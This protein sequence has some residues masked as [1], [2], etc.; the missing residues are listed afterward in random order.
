M[1]FIC[2]YFK[3]LYFLSFTLNFSITLNY[4]FFAKVFRKFLQNMTIHF[5]TKVPMYL[6][7]VFTNSLCFQENFLT[8]KKLISTEDR[9]KEPLILIPWVQQL[10]RIFLLTFQLWRVVVEIKGNFQLKLRPTGCYMY[11]FR[12][13]F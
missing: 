1:G 2:I 4:C 13:L 12:K 11:I 7:T 5:V 6:P 3:K 8:K 9:L 10:L